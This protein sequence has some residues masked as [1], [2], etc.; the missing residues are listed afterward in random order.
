MRKNI[1]LRIGLLPFY[2]KTASFIAV[3]FETCLFF[4]KK[5]FIEF[6]FGISYYHGLAVDNYNGIPRD[7]YLFGGSYF[8]PRIGYRFQK[9]DGGFFLRIGGGPFIKLIE[10]YQYRINNNNGGLLLN[11]PFT[12]GLSLGYTIKT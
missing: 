11:S 9:R 2:E 4:G 12:I 10:L 8:I 1:S 6:G 7:S 5:N 3:P